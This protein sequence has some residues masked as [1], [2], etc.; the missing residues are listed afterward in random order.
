MT[1]ALGAA[2]RALLLAEPNVS[3]LV[4]GERIEHQALDPHTMLPALTYLRLD[5]GHDQEHEGLSGLE[6]A[7]VQIDAWAPTDEQAEELGVQA[8]VQLV[9][10][11]AGFQHECIEL[12]SCSVARD[13]G[14]S[15]DK[16]D[17]TDDEPTWR[18]SFDVTLAFR[19]LKAA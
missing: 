15:K 16:A 11:A 12:D 4:G 19:R 17:K 7:T 2:L 10:G 3:E 14:T 9:D 1:T 8:V 6:T 18:Y 5:G 13:R